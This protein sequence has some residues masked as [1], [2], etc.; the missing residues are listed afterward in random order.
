MVTKPLDIR[1]LDMAPSE[2]LEDV[3]VALRDAF[4]DMKVQFLPD[5]SA[6]GPQAKRVSLGKHRFG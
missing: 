1:F 6:G 2:A 5:L 4:D 3:Y